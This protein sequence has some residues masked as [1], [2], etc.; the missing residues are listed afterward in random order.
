MTT[1]PKNLNFTDKL[2][3]KYFQNHYLKGN[4]S[5]H[6]LPWI[7]ISKNSSTNCNERLNAIVK[8]LKVRQIKSGVVLDV[9]CNL[10]FFSLSL[11]EK[12]FCVYGVDKNKF[13]LTIANTLGHSIKKGNFFPMS[14]S[15]NE[16]TV[17]YLPSADICLCLSIWSFWIQQ[18]GLKGATV[19]L[20][21]LFTKTN[22]VSFFESEILNA[23]KNF[24]VNDYL[25]RTLNPSHVISLGEFNPKVTLDKKDPKR[26]LFA[27]LK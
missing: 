13:F 24:S 10:G 9:G 7:G 4:L 14:M 22:K 6:P 18:Y 16:N 23:I 12:G 25:V 5:Y 8:F 17:E 2:I 27:V 20:K 11:K 15:I 1:E 3:L 21:T 26:E 19:I